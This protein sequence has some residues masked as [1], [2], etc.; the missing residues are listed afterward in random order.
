VAEYA[1][2][3]K[4]DS[5]PAFAW[6]IRHTLKKKK[7]FINKTMRKV[8]RNNMKFGV[9]IPQNYKEVVQLDRINGNTLWQ[10]AVKKGNE[11]CR[12][13]IRFQRGR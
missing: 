10:D 1:I 7:A 11:K 2:R 6:W 8:R 13:S 4:I 3:N 9:K 12:D 5:E